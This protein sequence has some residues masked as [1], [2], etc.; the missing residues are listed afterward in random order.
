MTKRIPFHVRINALQHE[1]AQEQL[2][3]KTL[4]R[5]LDDLKE[6]VDK[7]KVSQMR[8]N[9]RKLLQKCADQE[10]ENEKLKSINANLRAEIN[11]DEV[12]T[13]AARDATE[14]M[15]FSTF[16]SVSEIQNTTERSCP[17]C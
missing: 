8:E 12:Y 16:N 9:F 11:A 6:S 3:S 14:S 7:T 17:C 13:L 5:K 10:I 4:K 15:E 2:V 1:L